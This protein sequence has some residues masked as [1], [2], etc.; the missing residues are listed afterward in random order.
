MTNNKI[1]I[2]FVLPSLA[3]GGA[4]RV[5]SYVAQ[6]IDSE[7]FSAI[8]LIAGFEKDAAFKTEGIEIKYFNKNR[9]LAAFYPIFKYILINKP[10]I[11]VSAISNLNT[12]M[13]IQSL[14]FPKT[15]F[16]GREVSV[17]SILHKIEKP[18][19]HIPKFLHNFAHQQLD[20]II[21]QSNDMAK[22]VQNK[23]KFKSDKLVIINN[24]ISEKFTL[25]EK[26]G[27]QKI[28]R[29][30]T[31]GTLTKRKGHIRI[32][33]I[34]SKYTEP[35]HYTIVGD[36]VDK[37]EIFEYVMKLGLSD[38]TQHIPFT[39]D[40]PKYLKESD[41]FL[42]GSYVE[43]F[44]NALLESCAVGTP[45]I[46]FN[47]PGGIDEIIENG[48]NGYIADDEKDYLTK[49]QLIANREWDPEIVRSS[50]MKKY[51]KD[52]IIEQYENLFLSLVNI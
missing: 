13:G 31:V 23:F 35:F 2:I 42:Q 5:M 40:V 49:L 48:I 29:F 47:A 4:E 11:V 28:K 18:K 36:G 27:D 32:L 19:R 10:Q 1:K 33:D 44:P 43:G 34:L 45:V 9:A 21:C 50:V 38:I 16:I 14:F 25:K 51:N 22:D 20:K 3:A 24:P 15:K 12:I 30:I 37:E 17:G 26:L 52:K 7:K 39:I 8:L 41:V 6:N 46:A